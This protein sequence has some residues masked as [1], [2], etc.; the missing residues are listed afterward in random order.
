MT[1]TAGPSQFAAVACVLLVVLLVIRDGG[2]RQLVTGRMAII[3]LICETALW[4]MFGLL[5]I[6]S[7]VQ[8]ML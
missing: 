8:L 7:L 2:W 1:L 5:V 6:P 4:T 3:M